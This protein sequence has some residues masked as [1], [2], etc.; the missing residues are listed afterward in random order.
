MKLLYR[1]A[2]LYRDCGV[3]ATEIHVAT[4]CCPH[5]CQ[6]SANDERNVRLINSADTPNKKIVNHIMNM[7]GANRQPKGQ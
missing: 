7:L 6:G 1:P 3:I 2:V 4:E 5:R